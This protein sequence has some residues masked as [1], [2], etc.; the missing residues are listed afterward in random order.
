MP[1]RVVDGC[2]CVLYNPA[3]VSERS[4]MTGVFHPRGVAAGAEGMRVR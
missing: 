4:P 1:E 2:E 3:M